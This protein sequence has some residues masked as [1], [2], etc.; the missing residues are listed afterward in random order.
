VA[1]HGEETVHFMVDKKQID[2]RS[3]ARYNQEYTVSYFFCQVPHS[4]ASR[5]P[6]SSTVGWVSTP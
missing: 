3:G 2:K 1:G 5:T 4:K 6:Q